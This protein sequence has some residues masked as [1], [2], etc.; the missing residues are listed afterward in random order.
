MEERPGKRFLRSKRRKIWIR[1]DFELRRGTGKGSRSRSQSEDGSGTAKLKRKGRL[2]K[3]EKPGDR[4]RGHEEGIIRREGRGEEEVFLN[5]EAWI[6]CCKQEGKILTVVQV[7][8]AF[9]ALC[10]SLSA[11]ALPPPSLLLLLTTAQLTIPSNSIDLAYS[12]LFN[13]SI[14]PR[15]SAMFNSL[16][17]ASRLPLRSVR[18]N[19]T[20][21]PVPPL[22]A[23]IR[24]DLKAA[25]RAKDSTR[26]DS[27]PVRVHSEADRI[28]I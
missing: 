27:T 16:R 13:P 3:I 18:W 2:P 10:F 22:M 28:G 20:E 17:V 8:Q 21:T 26:C 15:E 7:R 5:Q 11:F 19:S 23:Q 12:L 24:S 1:H 25:M 9:T 6:G 14:V 4:G